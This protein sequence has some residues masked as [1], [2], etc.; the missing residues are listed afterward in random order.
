MSPSKMVEVRLRAAL[1]FM[2]DKSTFRRQPRPWSYPVEH[3][4]LARMLEDKPASLVMQ[5]GVGWRAN[6]TTAEESA[7]ERVVAIARSLGEILGSGSDLL[8]LVTDTHATVNRIPIET[9][10]GYISSLRLLAGRW[11]LPVMRTSDMLPPE[12]MLRINSLSS[13]KII[14]EALWRR[15]PNGL[16]RM[17]VRSAAQHARGREPI[18]AAQAYISLCI[19]EGGILTPQLANN[20]LVTFQAPEFAWLLPSVPTLFAY[21]RPGTLIRPW[22]KIEVE[23]SA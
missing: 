5:W 6:V 7:L 2:A 19:L 23:P 1:D 15:V 8:L 14:Q 4:L 22:F 10:A 13:D 16:Q 3:Y 21:W 9:V 18:E 20:L 17:L 12:H 11:N